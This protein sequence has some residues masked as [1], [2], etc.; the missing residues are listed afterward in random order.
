VTGSRHAVIV[1]LGE[2]RYRIDRPFGTWPHNAGKVSDVL[3]LADGRI[4]VL[5]RADPYVDPDDPRVIVLSPEGDYLGAW[6]G[7]EIADAHLMTPAP[8]GRIFVVDRDMHE[9]IIFSDTGQRLGGIGTRGDPGA[10]FNHPTDVAFAPNGDFYVSDGYA[11]WHVHRFAADGRHL[12]TWGAF[13]DAQGAFLEP[14]S[15]W[16]LPD[17]RVVVVDRCNNRL[18]VFTGEGAFLDEWTGFRRPVGIWGDAKG[19]LFVTDEVPSLHRL[20]QDGARQGRAR[21][22]LNGAHGI[23][24]TPDG[25]IYLA[26]ANPSR[27]SRLTPL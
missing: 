23:F 8:D 1:A 3:V 2:T 12:A 13:G 6:G 27:I 7:P 4:L 16:C 18:Q 11:G 9:I 5:L 20:S 25:T 15:L 10:P 24:G 19:D 14:H 22:M 17:G 26:E 21:P